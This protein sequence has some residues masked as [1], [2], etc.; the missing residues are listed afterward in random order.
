MVAQVVTCTTITTTT[1]QDAASGLYSQPRN[2]AL[3][4]FQKVKNRKLRLL[5]QMRVVDEMWPRPRVDAG[6]VTA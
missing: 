2:C 6:T 5:H 3:R 1:A 4:A